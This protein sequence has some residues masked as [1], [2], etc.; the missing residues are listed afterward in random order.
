MRAVAPFFVLG[1]ILFFY[2]VTYGV[3]HPSDLS[4]P[5]VMGPISLAAWVGS[6]W[7]GQRW[8]KRTQNPLRRWIVSSM[9]AG[10]IAGMVL[11]AMLFMGVL[12]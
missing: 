5:L 10:P 4:G 11:A 7:A 3:M 12:S 2:C 6:A 8:A 9:I 1:P